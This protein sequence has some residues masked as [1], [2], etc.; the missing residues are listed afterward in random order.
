MRGG[1]GI[2]KCP[3]HIR[4]YAG[5]KEYALDLIYRILAL[6]LA[7]VMS[8]TGWA[9]APAQVRQSEANGDVQAGA[10]VTPAAGGVLREDYFPAVPHTD[11]SLAGLQALLSGPPEEAAVLEEIQRLRALS[12]DKGNGQE[13]A[14]GYLELLEQ[15]AVET[16]RLTLATL[17]ADQALLD[18][19][20]AQRVLDLEEGLDLLYDRL[21]LLG[22]ELLASP[23]GA[24]L[25]AALEPDEAAYLKSY[26]SALYGP[27]RYSSEISALCRDYDQA[28]AREYTVTYQGRT[29][30]WESLAD[31]GAALSDGDYY[32]VCDLL[33]Q[34]QDAVVGPIFQELTELRTAQAREAGYGSYLDYA[35]EWSYGRDCSPQEAA[36]ALD[37]VLDAIGGE[38]LD[39]YFDH[40]DLLGSYVPASWDGDALLE[41]LRTVAGG[42]HG[43]IDEALDY[44]IQGGFA[45]LPL[46][47]SAANTGGYTD[48]LPGYGAPLIY[49]YLY[50]SSY[51]LTS[52]LHELGHYL[53]YYHNPYD[54]F[55]DGGFYMDVSEI[56]STALE[57]LLDERLELAFPERDAARVRATHWLDLLYSNLLS[58]ALVNKL[59][60]Y[61]YENPGLSTRDI[62]AYYAG[63]WEAY[64]AYYAPGEVDYSW[65]D[66]SHIFYYPG[67]YVSYALSALAA[68]E[69]WQVYASDP[70]EGL[71]LYLELL[72]YSDDS[73]PFDA[74]LEELGL[75]GIGDAAYTVAL[76]RDA[77]AH[78]QTLLDAC[79]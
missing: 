34:A 63:L 27:S 22:Q 69:I 11:Q 1:Y 56:H 36:D 37:A 53:N 58:G 38:L 47:A 35:Y 62:S 20:A 13:T 8:V 26:D 6:I 19:D 74:L 39:S 67:Y 78:F 61:I 14:Q 72:R 48:M 41:T 18:L 16:S 60:L 32:A 31:A 12:G 29:W 3:N 43:E 76:A 21:C 64:G 65:Q 49:N 7:A 59:E 57:L 2:I 44:L 68:L 79:R 55:F 33:Y 10:A 30:T 9:S 73:L 42:L 54:P 40:Y 75:P 28:M 15:Y 50:G 24:A 52:M 66:I 25:E 17:A 51:D 23:C 5:R 77:L 70:E 71:A 4:P 45:V 46:D